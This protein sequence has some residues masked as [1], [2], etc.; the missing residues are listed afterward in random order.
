LKVGRWE[1]GKLG[2]TDAEGSKLKAERSKKV[3]G[4]K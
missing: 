1:A 2:S 3:K 4:E